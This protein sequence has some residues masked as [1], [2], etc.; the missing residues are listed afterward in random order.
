MESFSSCK[1]PSP[2]NSM[3]FNS[4]PEAGQQPDSDAPSPR[5]VWSRGGRQTGW[6]GANRMRSPGGSEGAPHQRHPQTSPAFAEE[7]STKNYF[8]HS[9]RGRARAGLLSKMTTRG[10]WR[11][12]LVMKGSPALMM[13]MQR[14]LQRMVLAV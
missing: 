12:G 9:A 2:F 4:G 3:S 6:R 1:S 13:M 5:L 8:V 10:L 14:Q 7:N 11:H